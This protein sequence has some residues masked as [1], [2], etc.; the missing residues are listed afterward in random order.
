MTGSVNE[1][2]QT[3]IDVSDEHRH[4]VNEFVV[5]Q[6]RVPDR[7]AEITDVIREPCYSISHRYD[8]HCFDNVCLAFIC[9]VVAF[10]SMGVTCY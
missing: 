3:E 6:H 5:N 9:V 2:I 7:V 1:W 4:V 10:F 8:D